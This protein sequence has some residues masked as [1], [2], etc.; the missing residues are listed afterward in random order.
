VT[1]LRAK[2]QNGGLVRA[3]NAWRGW[4]ADEKKT[5][6]MLARFAKR[7]LNA[8]VLASFASWYEYL[9]LRRKLRYHLQEIF[10]RLTNGALY[11]AWGV[12]MGMVNAQ[13]QVERDSNELQFMTG[14]AREEA[15]A[16]IADK[17][18]RK[19]KAMEL[20][21]RMAHGAQAKVFLDWKANVK[22]IKEERIKIKRFLMKMTMRCV[23]S[24]LAQWTHFCKERKFLRSFLY[25]SLGG[26]E[27]KLKMAGFRRW[28]D[29]TRELKPLELVHGT[30]RRPPPAPFFFSPP[31][32]TH[33][34]SWTSWCRRSKLSWSRRWPRT[35]CSWPTSGTSR[36]TRWR[37]PSGT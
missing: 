16:K 5:R 25:R 28:K 15:E 4:A 22:E 29:T 35:S 37:P 21:Q 12:W 7:M 32:P 11:G 36:R 20:I 18:R 10:N 14:K 6:V 23:V 31:H 9:E 19:A 2:M 17:E 30:V 24:A 33:R 8:Q 13:R 27:A 26:K 3:I 1:K 34:W